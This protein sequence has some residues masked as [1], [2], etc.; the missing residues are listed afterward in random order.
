MPKLNWTQAKGWEYCECG[1]NSHTIRIAGAEYSIFNDLRRG[2][3]DKPFHL[4]LDHYSSA[5][6]QLLGDFQSFAEAKEAAW[7]HANARLEED[8]PHTLH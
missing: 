1:C 3:T 6:D 2:H 7:S 5:N 8:G 4:Y